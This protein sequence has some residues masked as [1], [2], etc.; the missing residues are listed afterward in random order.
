MSSE[1]QDIL[2]SAV[3]EFAQKSLL[4]NLL[5]VERD[6]IDD[7]IV[8]ALATQGFIG[9]RIPEK[10]GGSG[11][12]QSGYLVVL[13]ELATFSPSISALVMLTGSVFARLVG[14]MDPE[15]VRRVASGEAMASV[16]FDSILEGSTTA[17]GL[18]ESGKSLIGERKH[19]LNANPDYLISE[20]GGSGSLYLI[21]GGIEVQE[22]DQVLSFRGIKLGTARV[23]C[24]TCVK[25]ADDGKER[26]A[27]V[28]DSLD[29]EISAIALGISRGALQK[30][31][32]YTKVRK[33]FDKPLKDYG[34]VAST[35]SRLM[36]EQRVLEMALHN[37][38][39]DEAKE[40]LM[41]KILA[42]DLAKRASKY[43]LQFHGGY[44]YIEDFGVE[45]YYRDAMGL[46][47]LLQ[48][49]RSDNQRLA[50]EIFGEKSGY[51]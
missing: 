38:E 23:N 21:K 7:S 42:V 27:E 13:E 4:N 19:I 10:Y 40:K 37:Q 8:R 50:K 24:S 49:S 15:A 29:L 48:R 32:E 3:Q 26:L 28:M 5:K 2:K 43:A 39:I 46:S 35:I 44:G 41:I 14:D 18:K 20:A 25:L 33:T 34:P 9:S 45:K 30:V 22:E 36:S 1:E 6:G 11:I 17:E 31:I 16:A 51:L 12:D 47:I